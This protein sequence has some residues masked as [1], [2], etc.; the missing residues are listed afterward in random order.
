ME[1][2]PILLKLQKYCAYQERCTFDIIAK[3][4]YWN[5]NKNQFES[6]ISNLKEQNFLDEDRY[7][8]SFARG[9]F[10]VNKWGK[11]KIFYEL[12][13]KNI[14][15]PVI[16]A[17]LDDIDNGEYYEV[18]K[19]LILKK[20]LELSNKKSLDIRQKIIN[21]AQGKGFEIELILGIMKE[22]NS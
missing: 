18:L 14:P 13:H 1:T 22:L 20:N 16:Q 12:N 6:I 9:K 8:K 19:N 11:R 15:D 21:F 7:A 3:L 10:R 17:G 5:V 2:N 4:K